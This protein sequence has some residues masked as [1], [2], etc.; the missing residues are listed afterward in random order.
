[1]RNR[2]VLDI[3]C[4]TGYG[5]HY[6]LRK[7]AA[8]VRG[9]DISRRAVAYCREHYRAS[10]L[11]FSVADAEAL[12]IGALAPVEAVFASNTLEHVPGV[13]GLL[14]SIA[15]MLPP[16]GSAVLAVPPIVATG[17]LEGNLQ[18]PYHINNFPARF[19]LRKLDRYFQSV[20][21]YRHWLVPEWLDDKNGPIGVFCSPDDTKI[22]ETDFTFTPL[23][24]SE[25]TSQTQNITCLL[26]ARGPR[27][28][29]LPH[30]VGE[31]VFPEE[32]DLP[33]IE[34]HVRESY[35]L[36]MRPFLQEWEGQL[37]RQVNW[38]GRVNGVFVVENGLK[39]FLIPGRSA[40]PSL[41]ATKAINQVAADAI[42]TREHGM[43]K[44]L[45][46]QL[47]AIHASPVWQ[48]TTRYRKWLENGRQRSRFIRRVYDPIMNRIV[49]LA[50][51]TI[52]RPVAPERPLASQAQH[53]QGNKI[54]GYKEG[55]GATKLFYIDHRGRRRSIPSEQ[56]LR[57]H[58][59]SLRDVTLVDEREMQRY[60]PASPVA[61]KWTAADWSSP[62]RDSSLKL[63]EIATSRLTGAGIEFGAGTNPLPLPLEC[64]VQFAD[65]MSEFEL[66]QRAYTAQGHDFV[67]LS[68]ITSLETMEG[69]ADGALD[70]IIACHV[71]EHTKNPIL[72][73]RSAYSKLKHGGS[74]VLVVPDKRLTFDKDR[75]VTPLEHLVLDYEHPL[76]ERD[77]LHY[78]EFYS[79]AFVTPADSLDAR[80]SD[81]IATGG[82]IHFHTWTYESFREMVDYLIAHV[83]PS[84]ASMFKPAVVR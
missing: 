79:R 84:W 47:D 31:S 25:L 29:A 58:R 23:S 77:R 40:L 8:A 53:G 35:A 14:Q 72:A 30:E 68:Y 75:D 80:V 15:S 42:P 34:K 4:G 39:Q 22:R 44:A 16:D 66:R 50:S 64:D 59:F 52:S 7:G 74:F 38:E 26:V 70:F 60:K 82:D 57:Q 21:G 78:V 71:I 73:F 65:S 62:P 49:A 63:R 41:S 24:D 83:S 45:Q 48:L 2:H 3:G 10:N 32:W 1:M 76:P 56:H 19:W 67:E 69:I 9:V 37:V 11:S 51:R 55:E 81:A 18:N 33:A 46:A 13:D 17:Q 12:D 20:Q 6:L 27:S 36:T 43:A 61:S 54:L 28:K 5:S